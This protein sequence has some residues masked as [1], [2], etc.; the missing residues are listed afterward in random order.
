[1]GLPPFFYYFDFQ[2]LLFRGP[3]ALESTLSHW[4]RLHLQSFQFQ[5]GLTSDRRPV[6]KIIAESL[7]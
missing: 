3:R 4:S 1:M 6:V 2:N 7:S 5:G